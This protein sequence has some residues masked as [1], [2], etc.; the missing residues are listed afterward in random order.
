MVPALLGV[1]LLVFIMM[2]FIPGDPARAIVGELASPELVEYTRKKFG[3]D[4]PLHI[5]Y[6]IF[7]SRLLRADFGTSIRS[8]RPVIT[9]LWD[10]LA[11]TA[12]LA[13]ASLIVASLIGLTAGI[14]SATKRYSIFDSISM[15]AALLGVSVPVFWQGL[16]LMLV[17]SVILGW[18]PAG[19]RGTVF[20]LI[21]PTITLGTSLA[22]VT[23]RLTRSSMLDVLQQDFITTARSKGLI[24]KVV[25]YKHAVRNALIP[26]VT[27]IGLQFGSLLG[28]T[29]ITETV[30]AWPGIGRLMVEAIGGRDHPVVQGGVLVFAIIFLVIN[31]FVDLLYTLIDP[32]IRYA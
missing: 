22:A 24:E 29:V 6:G 20:H 18:L 2:R 27:I 7:M 1:T 28:G 13:I 3:L 26:V 12:E 10:R 14:V 17:F 31:L 19:G 11:N 23:A 15:I 21:L 16:M 8:R 30:F 4:R 32:R 5:Q 25:I 9:E